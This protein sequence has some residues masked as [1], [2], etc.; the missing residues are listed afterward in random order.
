MKMNRFSM[1]GLAGLILLTGC[2][3]GPKDEN[4]IQDQKNKIIIY[5]VFTRLF[6]NANTNNKKWGTIEENGVGKFNDFNDTALEAIRELGIT[7]IWYTGIL[8]HMMI[9]DYSA[10]GI[11]PDDPD[12]VQGRAG[13]PY[14][15]KD[16]Y[17]VDPDMAVDPDRRMEEFEALIERTH[18]HGLKVIIDIVPNHKNIGAIDRSAFRRPSMAG[19]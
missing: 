1:V 8:H 16:Y 2:S 7:H 10:Y 6:G 3:N 13:S 18:K 19:L 4:V 11:A 12:V 5:Q 9:T 14:A 15:I 17:N